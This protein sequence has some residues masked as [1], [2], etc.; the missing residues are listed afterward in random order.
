[1]INSVPCLLVL[2]HNSRL[3]NLKDEAALEKA[4]ERYE[5]G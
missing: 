3:N 1:M 2:S 5:K 4:K